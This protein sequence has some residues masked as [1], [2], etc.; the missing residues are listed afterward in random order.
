MKKRI[1]AKDFQITAE[2]LSDLVHGIS[3]FIALPEDAKVV[4]FK[5]QDDGSYVMRIESSEYDLVSEGELSETPL[6]DFRSI[7]AQS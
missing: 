5:L 3:K 4:W 1:Q 2:Q 7:E 6:I